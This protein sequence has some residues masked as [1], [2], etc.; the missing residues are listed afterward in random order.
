MELPKYAN[1]VLE[2]DGCASLRPRLP[3]RLLEGRRYPTGNGIAKYT[4]RS[5]QANYPINEASQSTPCMKSSVIPGKEQP[6]ARIAKS[7]SPQSLSTHR[8]RGLQTENKRPKPFAGKSTEQRSCRFGIVPGAGQLGGDVGVGV[9]VACKI[10]K[11]K[12]REHT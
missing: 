10:E 1:K 8:Q 7:M 4:I 2:E 6:P 11:K 9:S 5:W 3:P 12:T